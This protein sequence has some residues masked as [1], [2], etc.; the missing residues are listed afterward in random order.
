MTFIKPWRELIG[1]DGVTTSFPI[2]DVYLR[3]K[4]G[5]SIRENFVVDSGA[6]VS[7]G[8][9]RLS[10]A[11][12]LEWSAGPSTKLHGISRRKECVVLA[13]IHS[14]EV[15]VREAACRIIIPFCFAQGDA[16]LLLGREGFFDA[17]RIQFDKAR[18]R[19]IFERRDG[20]QEV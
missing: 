10:Q 17:F 7:L 5:R 18:A 13:T 3:T 12:G 19:T 9:R 15:H 4:K 20:E 6:D 1:P 14:V 16:P 11:L 8:P 2:L